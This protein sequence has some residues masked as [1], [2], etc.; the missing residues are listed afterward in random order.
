VQVRMRVPFGGDRLLFEFRELNADA[1][2]P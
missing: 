1:C 2:H